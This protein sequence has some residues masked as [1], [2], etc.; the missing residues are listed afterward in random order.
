MN[1]FIKTI[2]VSKIWFEFD[3][4]VC[5]CAKIDIYCYLIKILKNGN[6]I[7]EKNE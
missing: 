6:Y 2:N 3:P 1:V 4:K 5:R 7:I